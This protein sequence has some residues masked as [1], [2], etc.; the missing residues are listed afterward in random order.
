MVDSLHRSWSGFPDDWIRPLSA[1]RLSTL[2]RCDIGFETQ[3]RWARH[4][5]LCCPD[6]P[7]L[8]SYECDLCGAVIGRKDN[9]KRHLKTHQY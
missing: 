3:S 4:W 1:P 7:S 6:N 9:L 2:C 8:A 5:N